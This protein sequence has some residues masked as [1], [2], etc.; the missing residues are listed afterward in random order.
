ML[1]WVLQEGIERTE[2]GGGEKRRPYHLI[3]SIVLNKQNP[4]SLI[5]KPTL[6]LFIHLLLRDGNLLRRVLVPVRAHLSFLLRIKY[7]AKLAW[8]E[9]LEDEAYPSVQCKLI[10][11]EVRCSLHD[12]SL[13]CQVGDYDDLCRRVRARREKLIQESGNVWHRLQDENHV[14]KDHGVVAAYHFLAV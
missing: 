11:V 2:D 3:D 8:L 13:L 10:V 9:W 14:R 12:L 1:G 5:P 4:H 7:D 6:Q